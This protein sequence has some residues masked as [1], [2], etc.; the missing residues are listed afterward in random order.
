MLVAVTFLHLLALTQSF[1]P[2]SMSVGMVYFYFWHRV[3]VSPNATSIMLFLAVPCR[4]YEEKESKEK[5]KG[6]LKKTRL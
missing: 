1:V 5:L 3:S 2:H 4:W 6:N